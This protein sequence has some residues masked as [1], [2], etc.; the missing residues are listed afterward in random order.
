MFLVHLGVFSCDHSSACPRAVSTTA[1]GVDTFAIK[2]T[3][4]G[5]SRLDPYPIYNLYRYTPITF[6]VLI[7]SWQVWTWFHFQIPLHPINL[8]IKVTGVCMFHVACSKSHSRGVVWSSSAPACTPLDPK[9]RITISNRKSQDI[10]TYK[11]MYTTSL[12]YTRYSIVYK[13]SLL[14]LHDRTNLWH[15]L[16]S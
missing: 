9:K 7:G 16:C 6:V 11:Y 1:F 4:R 13:S 14:P 3:T 15:W 10:W 12:R 2:K 8:L 5:P